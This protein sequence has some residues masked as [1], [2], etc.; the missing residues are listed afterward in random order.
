MMDADGSNK[1]NLS[2]D[3]YLFSSSPCWSPDG[4]KIL[5]TATDGSVQQE[6]DLEV[7]N[8]YRI[9]IDGSR[10]MKLTEGNFINQSPDWRR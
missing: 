6:R 1:R 8:I 2:N 7:I 4:T 3:D 10:L 9:N 5:F